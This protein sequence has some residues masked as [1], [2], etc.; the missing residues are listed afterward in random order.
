[1]GKREELEARL[2]EDPSD[3]DARAVYADLLQSTGDPR[4]E[5][6]FLH[7]RGNQTDIDAHFAAHEAAFL[8]PLARF[9]KTFDHASQDAFVW[10]LGFIKSARLGYES[11]YAGDL[12]EDADECTADLVV[13]ALLQ[14]PSAMLL[15]SLT[16][17][18]NML[19]DGMYFD[20]VMKA[21][22]QH[23]A[24]TLRTLRLGE[25]QHA[26]PGG[27]QN[28][29]EYE[30][31]WSSLGDASGV[32]R[33]VPRLEDLRIQLGLGG[34]S[35]NGDTDAIGTFELPKLKRLEVVTGGMS[36]DCA[37]SFAAAKLPSVESVDLWFGCHEYGGSTTA[38]D[39]APLFE[40]EGMPKLSHLG[41]M[42]AEI[43]DDVVA[44]LAA[45]Q[46]L[47]RVTEVD[48]SHGMLTDAGAATIAAQRDRF[49]H[50]ARLDL[51]NNYLT[52][53][54]IAAVRGVCPITEGE[55]RNIED[56]YRYVALSE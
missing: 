50:L 2:I 8:G 30:I 4:G 39:L 29:Y 6:I 9:K 23:G 51:S 41:L 25:F 49:A 40:G 44:S 27:V 7:Q 33:V 47:A 31:S 52:A 37:R 20:K 5:L 32:W 56:E 1:M 35:S 28:D 21:I 3:N 48:L 14:H 34:S 11:N 12:D 10:H 22:A 26:G 13:A 45:S 18:M 46:L 42:N 55:Q 16:I 19:D 24:P 43:T 38:A 36:A 15:E 53:S 17:T 54:G